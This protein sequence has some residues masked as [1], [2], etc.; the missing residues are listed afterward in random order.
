[1][2]DG[3][4][5]SNLGKKALNFFDES[6]GRDFS[7]VFQVFSIVVQ[8]CFKDF[9]NTF[10]AFSRCFHACFKQVS[11]MFQDV[12]KHVQACLKCK[13]VLINRVRTRRFLA[14]MPAPSHVLQSCVRT[15]PSASYGGSP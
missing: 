10:Q 4:T 1:M 9:S 8:A 3:G 14:A 6:V 13:L 5:I 2:G 12:F 15:T 11:S 7:S